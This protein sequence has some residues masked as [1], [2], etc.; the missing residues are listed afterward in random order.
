MLALPPVCRVFEL[1][2]RVSREARYFLEFLRFAQLDNGLLFSR[3]KPKSN[4]L[5]LIS[6]HF[7][8]RLSGE[9]WIIW[10]EGRDWISLHEKNKGW[11]LSEAD[12]EFLARLQ[13]RQTD[14]YAWNRLWK[15]FHRTIA[16]RER[17]NPNV[18]CTNLP[19]WYRRNLTE[20]Q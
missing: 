5:S 18:Q 15:T 19:L 13:S 6:P 16:I 1:H 14:E 17:E 10:D 12:P 20:F 3:I 4:V 11:I 2:R 9:N 7:A 8:D